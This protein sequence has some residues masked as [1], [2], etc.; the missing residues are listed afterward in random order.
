M[1]Q[2]S[3]RVQKNWLAGNGGLRAQILIDGF[4]EVGDAR[5]R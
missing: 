1:N 3:R 5:I 2:A 4:I